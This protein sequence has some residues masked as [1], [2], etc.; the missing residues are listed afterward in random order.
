MKM[1]PEVLHSAMVIGNSPLMEQ[2]MELAI[3]MAPSLMPVLVT[4]PTGSGKEVIAS[5]LHL[6]RGDPHLPFV[7]LNC[8]AIPENLMESLLFGHEKGVFTGAVG[9]HRG[10]FF[11]A[12]EGTLFLDEIAE[13]PLPQQAK[14]LRVIESREF[15][16]LGSAQSYPFRGRVIAA[17]HADLEKMVEEGR[18]REDLFYRLHVL[19]IDVPSLDER[20]QDIPEFIK[21]FAAKSERAVSFSPEAV[22]VLVSA[23]WPGNVRQLKSTID[24]IALLNDKNPVTDRCVA[25]YLHQKPDIPERLFANLAEQVIRLDCDNKVSRMETALV[26]Q[27]LKKAKGNKSQAARYLGVHRKYVERRVKT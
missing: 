21:H 9:R 22:E 7:D 23:N 13:M 19:R 3:K 10:Y 27:A 16:P 6:M 11:M 24:K 14:L 8:A 18:F 2:V 17:T 26:H 4:G 12:G 15:R 1:K 20:R 25:K 5:V